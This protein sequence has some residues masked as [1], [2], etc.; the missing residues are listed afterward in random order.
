MYD[1]PALIGILEK[2]GFTQVTECELDKSD[3][4]ELLNTDRHGDV[5]GEFYAMEVLIVEGTK[6]HRPDVNGK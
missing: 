1:A 3:H 5:S 4:P 2:C 6:A